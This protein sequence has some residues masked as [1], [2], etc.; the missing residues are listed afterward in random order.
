MYLY[1]LQYSFVDDLMILNWELAFVTVKQ[2]MVSNKNTVI[3]AMSRRLQ[4]PKHLPTIAQKH[5]RIP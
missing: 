2:H 1:K 4:W 5:R 3:V